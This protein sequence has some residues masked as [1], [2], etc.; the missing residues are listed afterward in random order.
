MI[1]EFKWYWAGQ[2]VHLGFSVTP[3]DIFGQ[4]NMLENIENEKIKTVLEEQRSKKD[5]KIYKIIAK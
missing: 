3:S 2:K 5:M 1:I 4:P